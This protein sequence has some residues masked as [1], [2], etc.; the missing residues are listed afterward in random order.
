MKKNSKKL[1]SL[2]AVVCVFFVGGTIAYFSDQ[3][4]KKNTFTMG[5]F[6]SDLEEKF[7][8]PDDW[9]PGVEVKKEV[10][11]TNKGTVDLVAA[12]TFTES[13][14]RRQ[15]VIIQ[16]PD[17]KGN[18]KDTVVAREGEVLPVR[19]PLKSEDGEIT[20]YEELALK[21]FG[22]SVKEY[23]EGEDPASY[24]GSWVYL[25]D[26]EK[27]TFYFLYMGIVPAG[28]E[29]P[30]LL[31]SV[32]M[33]PKA[34]A[35]LTGTKQVMSYDEEKGEVVKTFSY[36]TSEIGYDS[37]HYELDIQAKTLQ[38]SKKAIQN[39][40]QAGKNELIPQEFEGLLAHLETMC[41]R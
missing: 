24:E 7:D 8:S 33:N 5:E 1:L 41:T 40:W 6:D 13:C 26:E 21:N 25:H 15:D 11:I 20:S 38:A 10:K 18:L 28:E 2:L 30:H 4:A 34:E 19:F 12:A 37:A 22:G 9:R 14:S 17:E 35:T 27:D 23:Q 3:E 31:E 16:E 29:S 32:R 36:T 39:E